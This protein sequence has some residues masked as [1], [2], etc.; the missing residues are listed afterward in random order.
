M[1]P[2]LINHLTTNF[3]VDVFK[4]RIYC[5]ILEI[6]QKSK[7]FEGKTKLLETYLDNIITT[8][9]LE[10]SFSTP[11]VFY[12]YDVI[13]TELALLLH[14]YFLKK[15]CNSENI[16]FI[17]PSHVGIFDWWEQYKNIMGLKSIV[18]ID[19]PYIG[20]Y[21]YR[22]N[23]TDKIKDRAFW[24]KSKQSLQKHFTA[25][26][27]GKGFTPIENQYLMLLL[28]K[29]K[30]QALIDC[31][32]PIADKQELLNHA[33]TFTDFCNAALVDQ[34]GAT[35]DENIVQNFYHSNIKFINP[36]GPSGAIGDDFLLNED[37]K[38]PINVIR[39]TLYDMPFYCFSEKS[40]RPFLHYQLVLPVGYNG[41]NILKNMNYEFT[42]VIDYSYS[43]I[44]NTNMRLQGMLNEL[45]KLLA[46]PLDF[47]LDHYLTNIDLYEHNFY[48]TLSKETE[49]MNMN[50]AISQ[51][52]EKFN[53]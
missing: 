6:F 39:E 20:M 12:M 49:L 52:K 35:Y 41:Y 48:N 22:F 33:E 21:N 8:E 11:Q 53:G 14:D 25:W 23:I 36:D 50:M 16:V 17:C 51:F 42:N 19:A 30:D 31:C 24:L 29:Y 45:N 28:L 9:L 4:D 32:S 43:N 18:F 27:S 44:K 26:I 38:C 46:L 10:K 40:F 37:I 34:I 47:F 3:K 5:D 15:C 7:T 2:D 13:P 1:W